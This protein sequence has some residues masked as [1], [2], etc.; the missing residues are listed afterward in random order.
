[1]LRCGKRV[2]SCA[3]TRYLQGDLDKAIGASKSGTGGNNTGD[4]SR[5]DKRNNAREMRRFPFVM[6]Q[7]SL[8]FVFCLLC[9]KYGG[10]RFCSGWWLSVAT[11]EGASA[12]AVKLYTHA[13]ASPLRESVHD[14]EFSGYVPISCHYDYVQGFNIDRVGCKENTIDCMRKCTVLKKQDVSRC[15]LHNN[16]MSSHLRSERVHVCVGLHPEGGS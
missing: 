7:E 14:S 16:L 5:V 15:H 13:C 9:T 6:L 10:R 3:P 2:V 4:I 12:H 1:M 11:V 8:V